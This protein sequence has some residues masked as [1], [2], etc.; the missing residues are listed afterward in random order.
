MVKEQFINSCSGK[1]SVHLMERKPQSLRELAAIR[2]Q[3]LTAYNKKLLSRRFNS[4]SD[5]AIRPKVKN[6]NA[7]FAKTGGLKCFNC[8]KIGHNVNVRLTKK[9]FLLPVR[10]IAHTGTNLIQKQ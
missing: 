7:C 2:E 5:R 4:K 3:Y 1:L 10:F 9:K 8:R 6:T